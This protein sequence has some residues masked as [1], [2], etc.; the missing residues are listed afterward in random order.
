V[1]ISTLSLRTEIR[2]GWLRQTVD[3]EGKPTRIVTRIDGMKFSQFWLEV[4]AGE[5]HGG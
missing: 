4:V 3:P 1:E 5:E 2:D